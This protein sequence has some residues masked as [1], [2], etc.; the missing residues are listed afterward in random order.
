VTPDQ[1]AAATVEKV[2][3][4]IFFQGF[5]EL[6]IELKH[7]NEG[8]ISKHFPEKAQ[9]SQQLHDSCKKLENGECRR[10]KVGGM[11]WLI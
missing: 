10:L 6:S 1:A 2:S 8:G 11:R 4:F 5:S 3:S 9:T 7:E